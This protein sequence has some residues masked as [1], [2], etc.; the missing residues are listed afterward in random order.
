MHCGLVVQ[1]RAVKQVGYSLHAGAVKGRLRLAVNDP[2]RCVRVKKDTLLCAVGRHFNKRRQHMA[3][4]DCR[5]DDLLAVNAVHQ[6]HDGGVIAHNRADVIQRPAQGTV[7]QR[8]DEQV[9]AVCLR[10]GQDLRAVGLA[11]DRT[12]G[13]AQPVG[14]GALGH[15]ADRHPRLVGQAPQQIGANSTGP[16]NR[17]R[18]NFHTYPLPR[19]YGLMMRISVLSSCSVQCH[20]FRMMP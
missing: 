14:A 18:T 20:G 3:V 10:G 7:F 6:A 9:C 17:N 11:V 12:P 1:P 2:Y 5:P 13:A 19:F 15:N 4:T 8:N 16:Q